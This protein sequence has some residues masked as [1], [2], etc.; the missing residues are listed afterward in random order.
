MSTKQGDLALLND[1]IAQDLLQSNNVAHLGYIWF[2]GT[3]RVTPIWFYWNGEEIIMASPPGMPKIEALK[4][5]PDVALTI[6]KDEWPYKVLQIRGKVNVD[7]VDGTDVP[8]LFAAGM[9]WPAR[10]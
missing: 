3:P 2:D 5:N 10:F 7:M 4:Q 8:L 1:P 6:D 9:G